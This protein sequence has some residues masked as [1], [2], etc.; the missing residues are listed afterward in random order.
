MS[1]AATAIESNIQSQ[2]R[3]LGVGCGNDMDGVEGQLCGETKGGN[4]CREYRKLTMGGRYA[5]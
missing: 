4:A 3:Q 1:G 5:V 2:C